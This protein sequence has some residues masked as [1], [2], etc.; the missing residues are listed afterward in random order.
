MTNIMKR[1]RSAFRPGFVHCIDGAVIRIL[2]NAMK[3]KHDYDINHLHDSIQVHPNFI[4]KLYEEIYIVYK[5]LASDDLIDYFVQQSYPLLTE[6]G[7]LEFKALVSDFKSSDDNFEGLI[8]RN[9][10]TTHVP[11]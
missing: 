2:I 5:D 3:E 1:K 4:G 9:D 11:V 10:T 7:L 8:K 6:T